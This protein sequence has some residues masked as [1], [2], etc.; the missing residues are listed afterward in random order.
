MCV[1]IYM[2]LRNHE[3]VPLGH[4]IERKE[5]ESIVPF[6]YK[7]YRSLASDD[8]T[9]DAVNHVVYLLEAPGS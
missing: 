5:R 6:V 4:R 7:L 3:S 1:V 8:L 2:D 9:E